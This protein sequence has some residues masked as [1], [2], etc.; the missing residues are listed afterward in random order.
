[1][2]FQGAIPL[3]GGGQYLDRTTLTPLEDGAVR[4][5]IEVSRD[6]ESWRTVFDAV[7]VRVAND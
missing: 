4:Q 5:V 6:G 2:R 7:Y 3:P 1:V